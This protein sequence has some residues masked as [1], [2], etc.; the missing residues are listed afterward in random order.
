LMRPGGTANEI[1][2]TRYLTRPVIA[3]HVAGLTNWTPPATALCK[4]QPSGASITAAAF[5]N[6]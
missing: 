4:P 5:H 6:L 2:R 1:E 3:A